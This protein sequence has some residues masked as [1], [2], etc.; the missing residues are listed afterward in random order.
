MNKHT[1]T[2]AENSAALGK[3][4]AGFTL[5]EIL[6]A[7]VLIGVLSAVAVVGINSLTKSGSDSA[8]A[9]SLDAAKAS[10]VV[11]FASHA[12]KY[13]TDF[14]QLTTGD[15]PALELPTGTTVAG[16]TATQGAWTLTM[17]PGAGTAKPTFACS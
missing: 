8:C 2:C 11:Y 3:D 6:I 12:N 17:T 10:S 15:D 9:A 7:I 1:P 16:V 13:P 14:T 4:D 5:V